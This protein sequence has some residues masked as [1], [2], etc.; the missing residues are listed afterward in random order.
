MKYDVIVIGGGQ[1]GLTMGY[2]LRR[3]TLSYII[4]DNQKESGGAW[5][6]TWKSLRL[7]SPAQWS[8][9][10]GMLMTGG[11][12]YYPTRDATLE[13]LKSYEAKYNLPVKR[14]VE[15]I[16]V[17]KA[18]DEFQLYTS[19]GL[20][21]AKALVSATGSFINPFIPTFDGI[22]IFG[23]QILHSSQYESPHGFQNKS[24]AIVGEGNSGA[25]IL[26]EVSKVAN[27]RWI[28]QKEPRFL[29]DHIDGRFLFDAASQM[30]EAQKAGKHFKPPS[31]GDIVMVES[32]KD[33]RQRNVLKSIRPFDHFKKDAIVWADGHEEK[34][35]VIIFCTGF[36]PGLSFLNSLDVVN[37]EGKADTEGTKSKKVDG[38]WLVGYG[39]WTG[40][41]SATLI[42]VG[43]TAKKTVDEI[44]G[45]LS[46]REL[47]KP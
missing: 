2:Y 15:V 34:I 9:L 20:Y 46:T 14:Q 16:K 3:T 7:F 12:D 11:T 1:S 19:D 8:S 28:T 10:P 45:Y 21:T 47:P 17:L 18:D 43:R 39:N 27:T 40:F 36:K 30:Y 4:L 23:G 33:A 13:Y 6:H 24:V 41:A 35:D 32:V 22:E 42:G 26:A 5:L 44:A 38:L 25:Q 29:P 37:S 31:L